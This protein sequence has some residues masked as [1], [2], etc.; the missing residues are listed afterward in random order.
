MRKKGKS[1]NEEF[2]CGELWMRVHGRS[3]GWAGMGNVPRQCGE[4]TLFM[5]LMFIRAGCFLYYKRRNNSEH[6][7]QQKTLIHALGGLALLIYWKVDIGFC[8]ETD[9]LIPDRI[10]RYHLELSCLLLKVHH[11]N[12][13]RGSLF[14]LISLIGLGFL[15]IIPVDT[16]A[17][18]FVDAHWC[19]FTSP[20]SIYQVKK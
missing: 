10:V 11:W 20:S 6:E 4:E 14:R 15:R 2:V 1:L 8:I 18:F 16:K 5:A 12:P 13:I 9:F 17:H 3:W 7:V 19:C